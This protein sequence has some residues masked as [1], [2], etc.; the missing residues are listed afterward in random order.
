MRRNSATMRFFAA[1]LIGLAVRAVPLEGASFRFREFRLSAGLARE[2]NIFQELGV[3]KPDWIT[4]LGGQVQGDLRLGK[5][6]TLIP[7]FSLRLNRYQNY[8]VATYVQALGGLELRSGIHRFGV[9]WSSAPGRLLYV[10]QSS[11]D[12]LYD[13]RALSAMYRVSLSKSLALRLEVERER[14]DYGLTAPG[15]NMTRNTWATEVHYK[16]S[17]SLTP[18]LGFS[19]GR[20]NAREI[21]YSYKKPEIMA[22]A[23]YARPN[24][25]N[26]FVRYRLAWRRYGTDIATN[27]NFGRHDRHHNF[28]LEIRIPIQKQLFLVFRENYKKKIS[29]RPDMNFSDNV[30]ASE[31]MFVF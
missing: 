11:G 1:A 14:Q 3:S 8:P 15:R 12:I 13:S 21:N 31:I 9:E 22:A 24:G 10:S 23:S 18:R 27:R 5:K 29:T 26:L 30:I 6:I 19:W 7:M 4:G 17:P 28:L 16:I 25:L 2:S 20:E